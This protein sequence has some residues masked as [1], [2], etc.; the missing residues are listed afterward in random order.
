MKKFLKDLFLTFFISLF[1]SAII[2]GA[3]NLLFEFKYENRIYPGVKISNIDFGNASPQE[4]NDYFSKSIDVPTEVAWRNDTATYSA[5]PADFSL[6][7]DVFLMT[8]RAMSIGRQTGNL[9]YDFLQKLAAVTGNINL[10]LEVFGKGSVEEQN[11]ILDQILEKRRFR[12]YE[13]P[14]IYFE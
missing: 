3:G 1:I 9:Y 5:K 6:K 2:A 4:V 10:P 7:H 12:L 11:R 8:D 14:T 13:E